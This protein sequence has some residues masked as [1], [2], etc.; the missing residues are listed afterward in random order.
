VPL[1]PDGFTA[2]HGDRTNR[3]RADDPLH[4]RIT[5]SLTEFTIVGMFT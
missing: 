1:S 3:L 4:W 5:L 2:R